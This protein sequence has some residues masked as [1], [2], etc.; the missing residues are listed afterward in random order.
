[1][2]NFQTV[3]EFNQEFAFN[4]AREKLT[5]FVILQSEKIQRALNITIE[6][7]ENAPSTFEQLKSEFENCLKMKKPFKVFSGAC[8]N[9]IYTNY[10]GNIS[11]RFWHDFLHYSKNLGFDT[12][13]EFA[14]GELQIQ[15]VQKEF[16]KNSI[17]SKLMQADTIGQVK[18]F[19]KY[20][21]F[22]ENQLQ[23]AKDYLK[24]LDN[25]EKAQ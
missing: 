18:Y 17:E 16:G 4:Q 13:S 22:V 20:N 1:M 25:F 19:S 21:K 9:T 7:S 12:D 10:H 23:F 6:D 11:F 24:M 3:Q 5:K 2:Q 8:E 14:V 15:A